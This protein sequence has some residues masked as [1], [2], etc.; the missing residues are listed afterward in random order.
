MQIKKYTCLLDKF[1]ISVTYTNGLFEA[2]DTEVAIYDT[3][4]ISILMSGGIQAIIN[5]SVIGGEKNDIIF[6]R[7][8]ELHFGHFS[9]KGTY[10][11]L[12]IY[13][14]VNFFKKYFS[15]CSTPAFLTDSSDRRRNC[16]H[17]DAEMQSLIN[18]TATEIVEAVKMNGGENRLK[19]FSLILRIIILCSDY[20]EK[21]T[22]KPKD[23]KLP[24]A[25]EYTMRT[26]MQNFGEKITLKALAEE[27][28]C[29]VAY[30]SRIFKQY[31]GMTVYEY[32]LTTRL[33]KSQIMLKEGKSV[34]ETCFLSGFN[35]CSNFINKFKRITNKT[36]A[37]FKKSLYR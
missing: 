4:K 30:L 22:Q 15:D 7:P 20:Y 13:V 25:V 16:I 35:D 12:D 6:F 19:V 34:T 28:G 32:I 1:N 26:V 10:A 24:Y 21:E 23:Y 27:A 14:P 33:A 17:F 5:E 9:Q 36:P 37:E 3:Y 11:Y 8:D 31:V 2:G 29:S 18:K